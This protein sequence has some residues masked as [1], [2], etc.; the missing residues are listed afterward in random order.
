MD[1][2]FNLPCGKIEC[3]DFSIACGDLAIG[4]ELA[5]SVFLSLYTDRRANNDDKIPSGSDPRGFWADALTGTRWGS[6]LW[7]LERAVM[8]QETLRLAEDYANESLAWLV[9]DGIAASVES[10]AEFLDCDKMTIEVSIKKP[11]G[12]NL[13]FRFRQAWDLPDYPVCEILKGF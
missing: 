6:R 1:I 3:L 12:E 8:S 9:S 5:N 4:N 2:L 10:K 7:L 13:A 11:N